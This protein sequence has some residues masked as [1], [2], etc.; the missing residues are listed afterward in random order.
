MDALHATNEEGKTEFECHH[1]AN[2]N[3]LID[4]QRLDSDQ[5]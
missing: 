1:F 2:H 5:V 4:Y 3:H